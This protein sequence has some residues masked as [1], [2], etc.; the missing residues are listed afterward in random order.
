MCIVSTSSLSTNLCLYSPLLFL[1]AHRLN[2]CPCRLRRSLQR[3][4]L[5]WNF[6][7]NHGTVRVSFHSLPSRFPPQ[8]RPAMCK[9]L[10]ESN[11]DTGTYV[12]IW[13]TI[14]ME[15]VQTHTINGGGL[16]I[17]LIQQGQRKPTAINNN[18]AMARHWDGMT[19]LVRNHFDKAHAEPT[20]DTTLQG[21]TSRWLP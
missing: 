1:C 12:L 20:V 16:Q 4:L 8:P 19:L 6:T 9:A 2:Q 14:A 15:G 21:K 10:G 5:G 18:I 13:M 11:M 3:N 7:N 17:H